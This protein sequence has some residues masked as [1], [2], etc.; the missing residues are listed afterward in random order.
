M[1]RMPATYH[2]RFYSMRCLRGFSVMQRIAWS[3][4]LEAYLYV[5]P[6][7]MHNVVPSC[8][9][10]HHPTR[11]RQDYYTTHLDCRMVKTLCVSDSLSVLPSILRGPFEANLSRAALATKCD[12]RSLLVIRGHSVMGESARAPAALSSHAMICVHSD[13]ICHGT[14]LVA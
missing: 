11:M 6:C 2:V 5:I 4:V 1:Q 3:A 13:N 9:F 7:M 8:W 10:T 12:K 14:F